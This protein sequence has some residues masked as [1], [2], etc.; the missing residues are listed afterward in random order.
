MSDRDIAIAVHDVSRMFKRYRHPRYRV[1]EAFGLPLPKNA[2]DEFWALRDISLDVRRG[3]SL[4]IIGQNGAGKSTLLSIICGRLQPTSG[5]VQVGGAIQALMDLGTGFHPEFTGRQNIYSSL[6]YQG[7]TGRDAAERFEEIVDFSELSEFI[8]QPV[9]TYSTGMYARLAFSTSTAIVP[10]VLIIDEILS[11]GDAYFAGKCT[12]RM[13]RLTKETG[14]TVLFVSHD[15]SSVQRLCDRAIWLDRG[16]IKAEGPTLDISKAYYASVIEREEARLRAQT[17]RA[18]SRMQRRDG[19]DADG[20]DEQIM[21]F[22]LVAADG[23]PLTLS[24]AVHRLA[25]VFEGGKR[26]E[27]WLGE[28]MDNDATQPGYIQSDPSFMIWSRPILVGG[29]RVRC[30]ENTGGIYAH[31]P[32]FFRVPADLVGSAKL[33]EIEHDVAPGEAIAVELHESGDFRRLR[34]LTPNDGTL[35]WRIDKAVIGVPAA[36]LF[37]DSTKIGDVCSP[38]GQVAPPSGVGPPDQPRDR[39]E[40]AEARFLRISACDVT[41]SADRH[42]FKLGDA[43]TFKITIELRVRIPVCW[44]AGIIFD[45]QGNR[46]FLGVHKFES[47]FKTGICEVLFRLEHPNIRQGEYVGSFELL[48]IFDYHWPHSQR[49]PFLCHWDR[50]IYFK[51]NED[52][53]GSIALGLVELPVV[54][55]TRPLNDAPDERAAD[56]FAAPVA[57]ADEATVRDPQPAA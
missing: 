25:L 49:I 47:G 12:E 51:I 37:A 10:E 9:K 4:A 13:R 35:D 34:L 2:C 53:D 54:V 1:F 22:R 28:P 24:H 48:P 7:I 14:A 23:R 26:F 3:E 55:V 44:L 31:A 40:T 27:V 39:W 50:C 18:V 21:L 38:T 46:V 30:L 52:Y 45:A 8:D 41:G 16:R 57:G 56:M 33:I 15:I 29:R 17:T 20:S 11:A 43:I 32:I 6:A 19:V 36:D 5:S 42:V